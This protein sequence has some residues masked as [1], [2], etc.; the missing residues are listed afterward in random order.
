[1]RSTYDI[2]EAASPRPHQYWTGRCIHIGIVTRRT[3]YHKDGILVEVNP[4]APRSARLTYRLDDG[5][6]SA[7][8]RLLRAISVGDIS[9]GRK[10]ASFQRR[11][12]MSNSG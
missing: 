9:K 1:M 12:A 11:N 3:Y 10:L 8:P 4:G 2:S 7:D 6:V 5:T